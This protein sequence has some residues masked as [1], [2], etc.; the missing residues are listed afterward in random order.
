[1]M[2]GYDCCTQDE[3]AAAGYFGFPVD[4]TIGSTPQP[5]PWTK[6]WIEFFREHRLRH[7]LR[8]AGVFGAVFFG[9]VVTSATTS[10]WLLK[11]GPTK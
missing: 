8:L 1:M 2:L 4:N 7:M 9:N 5:N 3:K 6:D 11:A 10:N